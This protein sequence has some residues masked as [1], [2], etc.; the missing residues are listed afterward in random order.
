LAKFGEV[1]QGQFQFQPFH[2]F[3]LE[4]PKIRFGGQVGTH[5]LGRLLLGSP[6]S[7]LGSNSIKG[8]LFSHYF[9][10]FISFL[11]LITQTFFPTN[12][13][14]LYLIWLGPI[15]LWLALRPNYS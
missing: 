13:G 11:W 8:P 6:N 4:T 3:G 9:T 10:Q 14:G 15:P 7:Q 5:Y 2:S 12:F 1:S